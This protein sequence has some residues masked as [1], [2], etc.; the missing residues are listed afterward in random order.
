MKDW[1][2]RV[3]SN[4]KLAAI[5]ASAGSHPAMPFGCRPGGERALVAPASPKNPAASSG[6]PV[7]PASQLPAG[8]RGRAQPPKKQ[9]GCA[10]PQEKHC[11]APVGTARTWARPG[12]AEAGTWMWHGATREEP[13]SSPWGGQRQGAGS[14]NPRANQTKMVSLWHPSCRDKIGEKKR[15]KEILKELE[16]QG[17]CHQRQWFL[18]SCKNGEGLAEGVSKK[19]PLAGHMSSALTVTMSITPF[20]GEARGPVWP[21]RCHPQRWPGRAGHATVTRQVW[22]CQRELA[23]VAG[24]VRPGRSDQAKVALLR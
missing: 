15:F 13:A 7:P 3:T 6:M 23:E 22:P 24:Q 18:F 5:N 1:K 8:S 4:R 14:K 10:K 12:K 17:R 11:E 2:E 20:L 21:G 19:G 9:A 16:P